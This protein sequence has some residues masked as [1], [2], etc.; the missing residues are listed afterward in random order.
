[1]HRAAEA[2][3]NLDPRALQQVLDE[4]EQIQTRLEEAVRECR[5]ACA[6]A[7]P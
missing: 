4:I 1:M 2:I 5:R 7:G 3:G 6:E